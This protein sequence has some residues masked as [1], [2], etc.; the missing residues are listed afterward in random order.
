VSLKHS[1]S[2]GDL[3]TPAQ[4]PTTAGRSGHGSLLELD[5][6]LNQDSRIENEASTNLR[7]RAK[8]V[9]HGVWTVERATSLIEAALRGVLLHIKGR[10]RILLKSVFRS[11]GTSHF[12]LVGGCCLQLGL[13][14]INLA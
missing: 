9:N 6:Q 8:G 13:A 10:A 5:D 4:L 3:L 1:R 11:T 14:S 12:R 2:D 7:N